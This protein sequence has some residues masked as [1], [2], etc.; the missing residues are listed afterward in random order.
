MNEKQTNKKDHLKYFYYSKLPWYAT[1]G[2]SRYSCSERTGLWITSVQVWSKLSKFKCNKA[3]GS[4]WFSPLKALNKQH[5]FKSYLAFAETFPISHC[6]YSFL[7]LIEMVFAL[8]MTVQTLTAIALFQMWKC[9]WF[10]RVNVLGW[11]CNNNDWLERL[12]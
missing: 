1:S 8:V 9:P 4:F 6:L 7:Q 10:R 5:H 12:L 11:D 2:C 3:H